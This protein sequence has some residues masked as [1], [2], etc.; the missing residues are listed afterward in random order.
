MCKVWDGSGSRLL[1]WR[2]ASLEPV[3]P[4]QTR[5]VQGLDF[6]LRPLAWACLD[7]LHPKEKLLGGGAARLETRLGS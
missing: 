5:R 3:G 4:V 2:P 7:P 6:D 1:A